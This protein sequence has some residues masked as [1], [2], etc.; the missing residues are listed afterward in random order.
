MC[1]WIWFLYV[2]HV[3]THLSL[4]LY[5]MFRC[6]CA[7]KASVVFSC[8]K[9][10]KSVFSTALP[11]QGPKLLCDATQTCHRFK[12]IGFN[13][14]NEAFLHSYSDCQMVRDSWLS[15]I[16]IGC[17]SFLLCS[18]TNGHT[19]PVVPKTLLKVLDD[20]QLQKCWMTFQVNMLTSSAWH[21][22]GKKEL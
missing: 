17:N 7:P 20:L 13:P 12:E 10:T 21:G 19:S 3:C 15:L 4:S 22:A 6:L 2:L 1:T 8:F 11:M 18:T 16:S 9:I 5:L 14:R